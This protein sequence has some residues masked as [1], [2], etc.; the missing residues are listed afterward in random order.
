[1]M[2]STIGM[3]RTTKNLQ[4]IVIIT[5]NDLLFIMRKQKQMIYFDIQLNANYSQQREGSSFN[6]QNIAFD[7]HTVLNGV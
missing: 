7:V 4:N 3:I 6:P 5:L 1:M 2:I